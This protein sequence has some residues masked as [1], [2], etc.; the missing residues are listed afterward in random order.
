MPLRG[1]PMADV[2][3]VTGASGFVG[4]GVVRVAQ[5]RVQW[6]RDNDERREHKRAAGGEPTR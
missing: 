5:E 2:A 1:G 6:T 4:R 3:L